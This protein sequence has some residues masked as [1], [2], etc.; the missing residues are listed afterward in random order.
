MSTALTLVGPDARAGNWRFV[1]PSTPPDPLVLDQL[2][3]IPD[4]VTAH[5]TCPAIVAPDLAAWAPR[6]SS[7]ELL[8][9]LGELV[10]PG[11][12]LLV[13]FA[14]PWFPGHQRVSGGA[15][16]LGAAVRGLREHRLRP[17]I[18]FAALPDHRHPVALVPID[19]RDELDD[20][21]LRVP[22]TYV[23]NGTR[24]PRT[25]RRTRQV[26]RRCAV[27]APHRLRVAALPGFFLLAECPP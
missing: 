9:Q 11:G 21:L 2:S 16:G 5:R 27:L 1:L 19:R 3:G 14:N 13:G 24:A 10:A 25:N 18:C 7:A 26:A 15:L 8:G 20:L 17:T 23:S 12:W 22:A 4:P 6:T